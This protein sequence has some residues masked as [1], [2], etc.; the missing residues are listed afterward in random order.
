MRESRPGG[1]AGPPPGESPPAPLPRRVRGVNGARPP[2][3]V[4]RPVLS[5]E[6]V[7][8][9]Q[10][11]LAASQARDGEGPQARDAEGP[12]ARD[13]EG[14]QAR[15]AE[16]LQGRDAEGPQARDAEGLQG[17]PMVRARRFRTGP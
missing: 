17:R 7:E 3:E 8:R 5:R 12:R 6:A 16:G 14:P 1:A 2:A 9:Y 11:A 4:E 15:D 13:A 10:A